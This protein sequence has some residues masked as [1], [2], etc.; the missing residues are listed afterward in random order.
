[1]AE[2]TSTKDQ[3]GEGKLSFWDILKTPF[4]KYA[5]AVKGEAALKTLAQDET[6]PYQKGDLIKKWLKEFWYVPVIMLFAFIL[7][8][9]RIR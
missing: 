2:I 7:I 4:M 8:L 1:M 9:K 3:P 6:S 5:E